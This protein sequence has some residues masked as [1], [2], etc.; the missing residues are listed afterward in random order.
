V[1]LGNVRGHIWLCL[2]SL[3]A[4]TGC[5]GSTE[6]RLSFGGYGNT[7]VHQDTPP[8]FVVDGCT[9]DEPVSVTFKSVRGGPRF[10][11]G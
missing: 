4:L 9:E 8:Y 6:G 7:L 11:H 1:A 2:G 3:A 5:S 10:R